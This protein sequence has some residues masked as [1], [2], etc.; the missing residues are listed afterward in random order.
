MHAVVIAGAAVVFLALPPMVFGEPVRQRVAAVEVEKDPYGAWRRSRHFEHV[1]DQGVRV[2]DLPGEKNFFAYY[3]P[4][5]YAS[6][7]ILVAVHGTGGTP[8]DALNDEIP[9]A[10]Q[11]DYLAVGV[12]AFSRET[13]DFLSEP[14]LYRS[15]QQALRYIAEKYQNNLSAVA[16]NGF[17]RGSALSYGVACLDAKTDKV[18]DLIIAHSGGIP[19]DLPE[20]PQRAGSGK[21]M[22]DLVYGRLGKD[23]LKGERFFLYSGDKDEEWGIRMSQQVEH[24]RQII[25]ANGAEVVEYVRDPEGSHGGLRLNRSINEK[26]VRHFIRLTGGR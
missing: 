10:N 23:P 7:R 24:A 9:L 5:A 21:L 15:I 6:G 26:A 20:D 8:Y 22:A 13:K 25:E 16:Y 17:S 1:L 2:V 12:N 18:F 3:V 19:L 11:F 14:D 4:R